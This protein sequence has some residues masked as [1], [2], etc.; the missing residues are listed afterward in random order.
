MK[1]EVAKP[2]DISCDG[3]NSTRLEKGAIADIPDRFAPGLIKEG[4]AKAIEEAK[5]LG[6]SPE[7]KMLGAGPE[8]K[9][10]ASR[11]IDKI[12]P[13]FRGRRK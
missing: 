2:F 6:A 9:G 10:G 1:V 8:N 3:V 11:M 7:N 13:G 5:S 12:D 4:Y